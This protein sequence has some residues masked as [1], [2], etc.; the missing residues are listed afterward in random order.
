MQSSWLYLKAVCV[1]S[2]VISY[3]HN[4]RCE[5]QERF[6]QKFRD[7]IMLEES[8]HVCAD[9]PHVPAL[10]FR[11]HPNKSQ[12]DVSC[13]GSKLTPITR[14]L[15]S[16]SMLPTTPSAKK[17]HSLKSS[18]GSGRRES[19]SRQT[20]QDD[21]HFPAPKSRVKRERSWSGQGDGAGGGKW[22]HSQESLLSGEGSD[23]G[24]SSSGSSLHQPSTSAPTL[25]PFRK[26]SQ[27][28]DVV[29]IFTPPMSQNKMSWATPSRSV[30]SGES[31]RA[32]QSAPS[33]VTSAG[34]SQEQRL[35]GD[36]GDSQVSTSNMT[37]LP[38]ESRSQRHK[39]VGLRVGLASG[40]FSDFLS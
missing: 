16:S 17:R 36:S 26:L 11:G 9:K 27:S 13:G 21:G 30:L 14:T 35:F 31:S 3:E 33:T 22:R 6:F 39:R 24:N 10:R 37:A 23:T 25:P 40:F 1:I 18:E 5:K 19:R 8:H 2:V 15:S 29:N 34:D 28:S 12:M 32:R 7:T 4:K 20:S 38:K